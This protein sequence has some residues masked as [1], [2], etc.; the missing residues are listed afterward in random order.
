MG[1]G[2]GQRDRVRVKIPQQG[3]SFY[4]MENDAKLFI[5]SL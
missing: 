3:F 4:F 1:V 5:S 2:A